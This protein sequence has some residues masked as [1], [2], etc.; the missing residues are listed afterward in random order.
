MQ[1]IRHLLAPLIGAAVLF[2]MPIGTLAA[3]DDV[4]GYGIQPGDILEIS[5]WREPDLQREVLVRP[6]GGISF[7]L[8]GDIKVQ[9][10]SISQLTTEITGRLAKF[11]PDPAVTVSVKQISGNRI[12]VLG[13]VNRP[14]EFSVMRPVSVMQA[15][16]M[17][18][19]MTP[20]AERDEV[21]VLRG[22][23]DSQ[24]SLPF[25]Y[26]AV[27]RGEALEQ[28]ILLQP[29]DVVVVP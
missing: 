14:G 9:G 23:G 18:G 17:A 26:S 16:S 8:V 10:M 24:Q 13:R 20:Y 3:G 2:S 7:P 1:I 29:G 22:S 19:G 11:V 4:A 28:N 27:E 6:D 5:A 12:Y 25:D 21:K 15:L